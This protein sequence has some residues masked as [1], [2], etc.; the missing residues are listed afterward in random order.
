MSFSSRSCELRDGGFPLQGGVTRC[1][2]AWS[3]LVDV[4]P[5]KGV[6]LKAAYRQTDRER[7]KE[8]RD[9][10]AERKRGVHGGV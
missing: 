9:T 6:Q 3:W 2:E 10:S 5:R 1:T 7:S 4:Q 8:R